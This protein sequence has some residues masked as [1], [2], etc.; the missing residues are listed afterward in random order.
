MKKNE[1]FE[2]WFDTT[3]YHSL[4]KNRNDD[5]AKRFIIN[6][7]SQLNLKKNTSVLDL[8]CGKGRH[9]ITLNELGMSVTGVDLSENSIQ[10]AKKF[11][12]NTL[13]FQ[14]KDM[15][16]PFEEDKFDYVFNLFT[17]FGYFDNFDDNKKVIE[18]IKIM[19]KENGTLVIDFMNS[20]KVV[21]NLVKSEIKEEDGVIFNISREFDGDHIFKHI[22]FEDQKESFKFTERVQALSFKHFKTLLIDTGFEII[23][24][25][26]DFDLNPFNVSTSD[27]L[28]LIA[29]LK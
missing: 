23:H 1:W 15:R 16:F 26:G 22:S 3:Y 5:E 27:R 13:K 14:V 28:I 20:E 11:E 29:K 8:A 2:S 9:S 19:L 6:L 4:Y 12:N 10:Y 18:A 21:Q 25:Y 7:V 17:S 24:S